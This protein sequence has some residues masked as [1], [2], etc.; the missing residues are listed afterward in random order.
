MAVNWNNI[1]PLNNSLN[2]GFEEL[3][4]QLAAREI[5]SDQKTFWRMGKPDGGKECYWYFKNGDLHMWQAKYFT[6]SLTATQWTEIDKSIITAIDNHPKLKKY[7]VAIPIDMPDGKVKGKTSMLDKWKSS[8]V[9][10]QDYANKKGI[11]LTFDF[12]GSS[13]LITRLAKK[14]NE[15]LK[16]FW[17][18]QE[19]FLDS[20]F[21]YKNQ[22]S[23]LALGARYT[24]DLNIELPI[25]KL[26]DGLARDENFKTQSDESY[27]TFIEKYRNIRIST[28]DVVLT[29]NL[30]K[31]EQRI[32]IIKKEYL[33][34]NFE[35]CNDLGFDDI[36]EEIEMASELTD[37]IL[38][39]LYVMRSEKE[40]AIKDVY[41][42]PFTS[43]LNTVDNFF[44]A[45]NNYKDFL[46]SDTVFL[47]NNPY[48]LLIGDAGIGKSHLLADIV[49]KRNENQYKSLFLL[50]ENFSNKDLPWTQI[51]NNQ[52]RI[53]GIDE[54]VF[55]SALN[56]QAESV[57]KRTIIFIDAINE[58]EG[59]YI[60]PNRLKSFINSFKAFPWL[61]LV[62]SLRSSYERLIAPT[63]EFD[64]SIILRVEHYG[65][66]DNEYEATKRF[67]EHYGLVE[68]GIP[69][70]NPEFHNPLFLKLFCKSIK[71][72]G[73][74]QMPAGV[75]GI[76]SIIDFYLDSINT[77]LSTVT[78]LHFDE[79]TK[80]VQKSVNTVLSKM[81]DANQEYISYEDANIVINSI[82][83]GN[84][85]KPEPFL[86][87]LLSEG[88]FNKDLRWSDSGQE[89]EIIYFAYQRFQDHL[90]VS[91]LLDRHLDMENPKKSFESGK[92]YDLTKD[93]IKCWENQ[94]L[95]EALTIQ[96]P[97][98]TGK[99]IFELAEHLKPI[100]PIADAFL[101]S[102][103]WRK[104]DC[105]G[106]SAKDFVNDVIIKEEE[107]FHSFLA[108]VVSTSMKPEFYFNA[109]S[110]HNFLS[111]FT[112]PERDEIWSIWLQDKY[113]DNSSTNAISR[114]INWAWKEDDKSH[115]KDEAIL[116]ASTTL[117]WFLCSANRYLRDG[118]T[119]ALICLLEN[120]IHLLPILLEKFKDVN[121]PYI[122]ERIYAVSYGC[123]LRS[124]KNQN[125]TE[126]CNYI[127]KTIFNKNK[128]VPNILLRD[129]AR[130][131]IEF[132][133]FHNVKLDFD[134][135]KIRPP[136][137]SKPLPL[138]Y[139]SNKEIDDKYAPKGEEGH[140]GNSQWGTTAILRSMT[141]EYGRK[142]GGYGDFGRYTFQ[143]AMRNWKV[144]YDGLSNYAIVRIFE[145]GYDPKIFSEFDIH[146]GSGRGSGHME[147]IGKKY[148]WI[149]LNELL[150]RVSD[151]CE[152][153]DESQWYKKEKSIPYDG[154]W[155]P[156]VRDID[157]TMIIKETKAER[158]KTYTPNW[159]FNTIYNDYDASVKDW[160]ISTDNLPAPSD[161]LE[162]TDPEGNKWLWL[163]IDSNWSE[164]ETLGEDKY[165][166]VR[167]KLAYWVSSYFVRKNDLT[168]IEKNLK[169]D[170]FR[171]DLPEIRTMTH[172]FSREYYWSEAFAFHN[173]PYYNGDEW[174]E[175]YNRKSDKLIG[176]FHRTSE[177]FLWEEEYDCSKTDS[178]YYHKPVQKI[179][180]GLKLEFSQNE[181]ELVD[182]NGELICF[183][184]S[185]NNKSLMGLLV[186]KDKL[187]EWLK[188][189][190][191]VLLWNV[192]GEKQIL[193][194]WHWKKGE[195][196]GQLYLSGLY[197]L[198]NQEIKGKLDSL[199]KK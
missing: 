126:L 79:N 190:D 178:I 170:F 162:V 139:P 194:D 174:I 113:G 33:S 164:P 36:L 25:A 165:D 8:I 102:L 153:L 121:D 133:L 197:K 38:T 61:G 39:R 62:I 130:G 78:E 57:Q 176:D 70:L 117:S 186:R 115:I 108:T 182:S 138:K 14:E 59:V 55:L 16:Y 93:D 157:P 168:K 127:Y 187:I 169:G 103:I 35:G 142:T 124:G 4:C 12:W 137:K 94:N 54:L 18:N 74:T 172:V 11:D 67:F 95:V 159:W 64:E 185:V 107:L 51:L 89:F 152:L 143:S 53:S 181:G 68:P 17:F 84:C 191:L 58:G 163:D 128:I 24:I 75:D 9:K 50:G 100:Y 46:Q 91:M 160:L 145:L 184:P 48:L 101:K 80:L 161:I 125:L 195:Y 123:A 87:K 27:T 49:K 15:G 76:T 13:Q 22:E 180:E 114:L 173:K 43:E 47:G 179:K 21:N 65:F 3:V 81:V 82:F 147:R 44:S 132:A 120:R 135:A 40:K 31:L 183:D 86:K 20:W 155:Q 193:G 116:L 83:S 146:Q 140:Y 199:I 98:R 92:L 154:P 189:E 129:Y 45:I 106:D 41:N 109:E 196:L 6:T 66:A 99:E 52:L 167:K 118:A 119:K 110:L 71:A 158:Y 111:G 23:T 72:K 73:L 34:I 105:I 29:E 171:S 177:Y 2:D 42:R 188:K 134:T 69:I 7:Y 96:L 136:Y 97:E 151:Q 56:S 5:I 156:N 122:L 28:D 10:W 90:T 32:N 141:T 88:I 149:V 60:W 144:N 77:K 85:Y 19:E 150:A 26:F 1:R 63:S 166:S 198:E 175:V 37:K 30:S 112:M 148:Q 104:S 131:V 192:R